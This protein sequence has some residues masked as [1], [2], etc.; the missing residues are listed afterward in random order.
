MN[1][2]FTEKYSTTLTTA[3]LNMET[4]IKTIIVFCLL[5]VLIQVQIMLNLPDCSIQKE[6]SLWPFWRQNT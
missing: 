4:I 5:V 6:S 3:R 2:S 1:K